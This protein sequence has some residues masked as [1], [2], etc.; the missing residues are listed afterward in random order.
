MT[1]ELVINRKLM[2]D[3]EGS[4]LAKS[5]EYN[6]SLERVSLE[7]NLLGPKFLESLSRTLM[8]NT[9]LKAIDIE[10]NCLTKGSEN[11]VQAL[12]DVY[13]SKPGFENQ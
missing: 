7:G 9:S 12:C 8:V 13:L 6:N 11:G 2:A 5:L 1:K 3:E 4:D 10:G